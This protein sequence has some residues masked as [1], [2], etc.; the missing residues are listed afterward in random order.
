[1]IMNMVQAINAALKQEM[2]RDENVILLGEDI[3]VNGGVFRVTEGLWQKFGDKRVMDTPL[4]ESAL[5]GTSIGMALYGLRP[6]PEIQF[7]GFSIPTLDQLVNH[8]SRIRNRTRGRF[9]VPLTVRIP[10]SGGIRAL[11]HHSDSPETYFAHTP[12]LTVVV[13]SGPY[14]AKGLLASAIRNNDPVIYLEPKRIYR[15]IKEEVPEEEYT[16]PIGEAKVVQSG[17][18]ITIVTYGAILRTVREAVEKIGDKYSVEVLDLRSLSPLDTNAVIESVKKTGRCVIVHEAQRTLGMAAEIIAR[19]NEKALLNL[20]APVERVTGWDV[21]YPLPK[22]EN[23][24]LPNADRV[25]EAVE[26]TMSF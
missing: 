15:A 20:E 3:G 26:R 23:Y 11:E 2:E 5:V 12:G 14:D 16:I 7:D 17:G 21:V 22:L 18:D 10:Y 9:H 6:V 25:V 19:I 8:A 4:A 1:M 24:Y 13:P